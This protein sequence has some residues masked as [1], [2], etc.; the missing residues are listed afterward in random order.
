MKPR[1][2]RSET[3]H[4][5]PGMPSLC[6]SLLGTAGRPQRSLSLSLA[7]ASWWLWFR[8]G[9]TA[10]PVCYF[11]GRRDGRG[12]CPSPS[13]L[14]AGV[15][16]GCPMCRQELRA[17]TRERKKTGSTPL[18]GARP[19]TPGWG[20]PSRLAHSP[21]GPGAAVPCRASR[22]QDAGGE[23]PR[24]RRDGCCLQCRSLGAGRGGPRTLYFP[25]FNYS[26]QPHLMS[27]FWKCQL[28]HVL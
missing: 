12:G 26:T 16:H 2:S 19:S 13:P 21:P 23:G 9:A 24:P 3:T 7:A 18:W 25:F 20:P 28:R 22:W 6:M 8:W 27:I 15:S 10:E 5:P 4:T 11:L 1:H 14:R 17:G